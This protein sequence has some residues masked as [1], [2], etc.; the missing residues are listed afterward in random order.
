M[1][2][3][4]TDLICIKQSNK[5]CSPN[6]QMYKCLDDDDVNEFLTINESAKSLYFNNGTIREVDNYDRIG[7]G[8][9][10]QSGQTRRS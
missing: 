6:V 2:N 3:V 10:R 5:H 7:R 8:T 1:K 9:T 4:Y